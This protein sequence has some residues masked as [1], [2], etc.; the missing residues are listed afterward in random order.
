MK[1]RLASLFLAL[2]LCLSVP[3]FAAETADEIDPSLKLIAELIAGWDGSYELPNLDALSPEDRETVKALADA[4]LLAREAQPK[5]ETQPETQDEAAP[6]I[7]FTDVPATHTF[8]KGVMYCAGKGVVNGYAD[9]T[10]QPAKT[11]TNGHF[12]AMLAR[13]FYPDQISTYESDYIKTTYGAFGPAMRTLVS[14]GILNN[15]SL[16]KEYTNPALLSASINRYDMA[17]MMTSIMQAKGF[18]ADASQKSAVQ[19]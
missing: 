15:T 8:Y 11:I 9:G 17:Q 7:S 12:C 2:A 13:A 18:A 10:F 1:K 5:P 16:G 4:I 6:G 19:A 14:N 3:A